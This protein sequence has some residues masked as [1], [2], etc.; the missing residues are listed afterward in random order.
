MINPSGHKRSHP[1]HPKRHWVYSILHL[2][3]KAI[4]VRLMRA[5]LLLRNTLPQ[6]VCLKLLAGFILLLMLFSS[7]L[8]GVAMD[9]QAMTPKTRFLDIYLMNDRVCRSCTW[10]WVTTE[11]PRGE[12][13][14]QVKL[15]NREGHEV[16]VK[17]QEIIGADIHPIL[18][19]LTLKSLNG[20]GLPGS[21]IAPEAFEDAND[22][23]C[24][25]CDAVGR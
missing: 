15:T 19:K 14:K 2:L 4:R 8:A 7:L 10:E 25:Y 22:Y 16:I 20:I 18:R 11:N 24:K 1:F 5:S 13:Q 9:A 23:T 12:K 21:I 17:P 6:P 3:G